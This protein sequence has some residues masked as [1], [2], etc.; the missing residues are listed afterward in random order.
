MHLVGLCPKKKG[1][2]PQIFDLLALFNVSF[3][4]TFALTFPIHQWE[5]SL[6]KRGRWR[7]QDVEQFVPSGDKNVGMRDNLLERPFS[8]K[9]YIYDN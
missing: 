8:M 1:S 2:L 6:S 7:S 5:I 9:F 4:F 3:I